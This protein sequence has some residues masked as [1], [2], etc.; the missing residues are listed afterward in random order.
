V[1][2][3]PDGALEAGS[4]RISELIAQKGW[5]FF[6]V[7][8]DFNYHT[9]LISHLSDYYNVG[10]YRGK[11]STSNV[12]SDGLLKINTDGLDLMWKKSMTA[13]DESWTKWS[14]T[15]GYT[16][17]GSDEL[18]MK[19]Y[20][21]YCVTVANGL[22]V[23]VYI[24]H[25]DA[26]TGS[27][28]IAA[29][30][31][32]I[33]QLVSAIKASDNHRPIIIMGDTN[34]R[35]TRDR[36]KELL[37]DAINDDARF[38][39][40]DPWVDFVWNGEYPEYGAD[41]MMTDEYGA[42]KGEIVDKIFYIN[43]TDANGVVLTANS[44]LHDTD[45]SYADGTPISDHYPVVIDFTIQ[46]KTA[47]L[48]SGSYYLRNVKTGEFL[49]AGSNWGTHAVVGETGNYIALE[50][51]DDNYFLHSTFG[52][53]S[54]DCWMDTSSKD[55][56]TITKS[57][58]DNYLITFDADGV[59][60]A[61]TVRDNNRVEA[62]DFVADD[63][64]Q[65]WEFVSRDD[66]INELY[67]ATED[68]PKDATFFIRAANFSRNDSDRAN[69][70][71]ESK[72]SGLKI[73]YGGLDGDVE[74]NNHIVEFYN[75]KIGSLST[76]KTNGS[77]TQT[78]E[79]LPNGKYRMSVQA[80]KREEGDNFTITANGNGVRIP[81]IS[82]GGATTP[83]DMA[84]AAECFNAGLYETSVD[85]T[86]TDHVLTVLVN[87]EHTKSTKWYAF[88]NFKL[89]YMG[90]TDED[91]TVYDKVKAAIDDAQAKAE[92]I[93][94]DNYD[95]SV[96]EERYYN[97]QLVGNGDDE[98]KMT[99][100]ALATA[101]SKQT[102]V[103]SDMRY[104]ILN[105]S[106]EMGD[107]SFWTANEGA[108][109]VDNAVAM[110]AD[111]IYTCNATSLSQS[112]DTYGIKMPNGYYTVIALL[113]NGG[114]ITANG[115]DDNIMLAEDGDFVKVGLIFK[116]TDG[117][118]NLAATGMTAADNFVVTFYGDDE[119]ST[120]I[121]DVTISDNATVDVYNISGVLIRQGVTY[122]NALDGLA[123]G[124]YIVRNGN[125]A[126]KLAK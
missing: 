79:G 119:T 49:T 31:S 11:V 36:L 82:E 1:T 13:T 76:T 44:Y 73:N 48:T 57:N 99:Y 106:F 63:L 124:V 104:V 75:A 111:G 117:I 80:F 101:S 92:E 30:E 62:D 84:S 66:L 19:G 77:L 88:D 34:C 70:W 123:H 12:V 83:N 107:L 113:A 52:Y 5:D 2:L 38:D 7:S 46:N 4:E 32:Q 116:V 20:R 89:T 35:Y 87:K 108:E 105:N 40:H 50:K 72:E 122:S 64:A 58:D 85:F 8:E 126:R 61:L 112:T 81:S 41:A 3:N 17:Q 18:L 47:N 9:E 103:G 60:K 86:I 51:E 74:N 102:E 93:G 120:G 94:L 27:K 24:H 65:E 115:Y 21:Y 96:V 14:K 68:S 53:I 90:L 67:D 45:F 95:N 55:A 23:D 109:V 37:I 26:E 59:T 78:A 33:N 118:I 10:T 97:H 15:N 121:T 25:M 69:Y 56:Y 91:Q 110:N 54:H 16:D 22:A 114:K 100:V 71:T 43:N 42:Q 29:R 39:I 125:I 98:V 6:G 28:D